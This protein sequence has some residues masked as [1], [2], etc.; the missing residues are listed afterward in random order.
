MVIKCINLAKF[1]KNAMEN[2]VC[3]IILL[4]KKY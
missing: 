3:I 1:K 2:L 4:R